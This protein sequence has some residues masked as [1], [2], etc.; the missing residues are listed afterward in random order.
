MYKRLLY[1]F[2]DSGIYMIFTTQNGSLKRNRPV[3]LIFEKRHVLHAKNQYNH[4]G[5]SHLIGYMLHTKTSITPPEFLIWERVASTLKSELYEA[6][7]EFLILR[8]GVIHTKISIVT[9]PEFL[10]VLSE[11][12]RLNFLWGSFGRYLSGLY[13]KPRLRFYL[14]IE[15]SLYFRPEWRCISVYRE[16]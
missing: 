4:A 15:R 6:G 10:V 13:Y 14:N 3:F 2:R 16:D 12:P 7:P 9:A 5:I 1:I 11:L 8:K